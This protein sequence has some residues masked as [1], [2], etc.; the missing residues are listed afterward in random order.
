MPV[1]LSLAED[2]S[3]A[4]A[5]PILDLEPGPINLNLLGLVVETSPICLKITA[6]DEGGLLG[7]LLCE[8]SGLLGGGLSLG[9]LLGGL[10]EGQLSD[11]LTGLQDLLNQAL[12]NLLDAEVA[13]ITET[14]GGGPSC[15]IL[16]LEL[17]PLDLTLLG[18]NVYL[19]DCND[20]PVTVDIT[21]VRG[22]LLGTL[23]CQLLG[24][25]D[26]GLGSTLGDIVD[27]PFGLWTIE[28]IGIPAS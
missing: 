21:V 18:L 16:N 25:G 17:G 3:D 24:G 4:G 19:D 22:Q 12:G 6:Y 10:T 23:L 2:Q 15:A 9:D 14:P 5:C 20:G 7:D 1:N 27:G 13:N 8:V 11:L 28:P 26:V